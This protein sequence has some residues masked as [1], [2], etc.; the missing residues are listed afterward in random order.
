MTA[1]VYLIIA[2]A[3]ILSATALAI[4]FAVLRPAESG[5]DARE[6]KLF[7]GEF[8]QAK[9]TFTTGCCYWFAHILNTR[10][11]GVTMYDVVDNHFVQRIGGRLYDVTGDVTDKYEHSKYLIPWSEMERYDASQYR[12]VVRDCVEKRVCSEEGD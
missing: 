3:S 4:L 10:F 2:C 1:D 7:I 5:P 12:R 11:G 9:T 6:I 8:W